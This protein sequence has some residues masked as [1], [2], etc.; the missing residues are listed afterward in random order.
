MPSARLNY[1]IRRY[2]DKSCT[3]AEK[4]ELL[5][6]IG[7]GDQDEL[8]SALLDELLEEHMPDGDADPERSE[9]LYANILAAVRQPTRLRTVRRWWWAA[10]AVLVIAAAGALWL[11]PHTPQQ[12]ADKPF[13]DVAPGSNKAV[14][15]LADG[16]VVQLDSAVRQDI[17]QEAAQLHQ[18]NGQLVYEATGQET[19]VLQY[20]TLATPRGGQFRLTLPDGTKVWLNAASSI[21]YPIAFQENERNVDIT[22]EAY[23]E[24]A[25][26]AN[27]P[28]R[29]R[30]Q[31]NTEVEVLGTR[32][33]INAYTD[34]NAIRTTLAEGSVKVVNGGEK[35]VLQPGQQAQ[36]MKGR[37]Q[38]V[39]PDMAQVLAWKNGIFNFENNTLEEVM[40]QLS[41]WYDV[42]VRYTGRIPERTFGGELQRSLQL[43]QV[44]EVLRDMKLNVRLEDGKRIEVMP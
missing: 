20:N 12:T 31:E 25:K 15:T 38:V 24:V 7:S 13:I 8:A 23:F 27:Q 3:P 14:L 30:I 39:R 32:F 18:Q 19:A 16:S 40:R 5:T 37:I 29:V 28:F 22:G 17:Q 36:I 1:L 44:L 43:S 41:R 35:I 26:N 42:E 4:A 33:N 34:E 21:R 9:A 10:A 11:R 2:Y 6:A